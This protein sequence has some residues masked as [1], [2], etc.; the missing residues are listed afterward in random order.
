MAAVQAQMQALMAVAKQLR[1]RRQ[2]DVAETLTLVGQ[3]QIKK[4]NELLV[5]QTEEFD[6]LLP[7]SRDA[8]P[9]PP[10]SSERERR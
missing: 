4:A 2:V 10:E 6:S 9:R 8:A 3:D 5:S 1:D 7:R